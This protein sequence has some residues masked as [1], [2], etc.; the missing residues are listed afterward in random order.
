MGKILLSQKC[1]VKTILEVA[2]KI[3]NK[4]PHFPLFV[5]LA[6]DDRVPG[7]IT[8]A[9]TSFNARELERVGVDVLDISGGLCGSR[10][11]GLAEPYFV[12]IS[13]NV[14][15][16]I[17]IPVIVT[18]GIRERDV[19]EQILQQEKAN[20]IGLGRPLL[21]DPFWLKRRLVIIKMKILFLY[22]I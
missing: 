2:Q 22:D 19:A 17:D 20:L 21:K 1:T 8:V 14:K 7:G 5:R 13:E 9:D 6:G 12:Y 18:G 10:P 15:A 3:R 4:V 11:E 16:A